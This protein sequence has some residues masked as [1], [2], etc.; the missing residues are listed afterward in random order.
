M[1]AATSV[2]DA[3]AA[4]QS[5]PKVAAATTDVSTPRAVLDRYCVRCHNQKLKTADLLLDQLDLARL[6]DH[7]E[8]AEKVIRKLR[9]GLMPPLGLPRPD[10]STR[11]AL[12]TWME[13]R[14]DRASTPNFDPPGLHRLNRMEYQNAIR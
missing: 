6:A 4:P 7:A 1:L 13:G 8:I 9:A 11:E 2:A 5:T 12:I 3:A 14:L 10:A